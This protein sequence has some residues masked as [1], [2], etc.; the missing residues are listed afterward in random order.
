MTLKEIKNQTFE[1]QRDLLIKKL[2]GDHWYSK[3]F[4]DF[5]QKFAELQVWNKKE[6]FIDEN[7]SHIVEIN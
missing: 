6:D 4:D 3:S 5:C 7:K 2:Y 1:K